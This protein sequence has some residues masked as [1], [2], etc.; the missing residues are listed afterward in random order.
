MFSYFVFKGSKSTECGL[1]IASS[2]TVEA[3]GEEVEELVVPGRSGVLTISNGRRPER[4]VVYD[5]WGVAGFNEQKARYMRRLKAWLL[6]GQGQYYVLSD[7]YDPEYFWEARYAGGIENIEDFRGIL[8]L[9]LTFLAYPYKFSVAGS[10]PL[11]LGG[12][13]FVP[14][15]SYTIVNPEAWEAQPYFKI[16]G[17]GDINLEVNGNQWEFS[18][19]SE[20]IEIDSRLMDTFKGTTSAN[21]QKTGDGYPAFQPGENTVQVSGGATA[22]T[23]VPRWCAL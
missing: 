6:A 18:D 5:V 9:P 3:P 16:F 1:V 2:A 7:T 14:G 12:G 13:S 11:N 23:V 8:S 17:N 15:T 4:E 22:V 10:R 21:L 19:V 20:Y